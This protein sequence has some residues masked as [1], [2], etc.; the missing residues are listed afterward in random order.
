MQFSWL[1]V[2]LLAFVVVFG[3][4]VGIRQNGGAVQRRATVLSFVVLAVM[5]AISC[6]A[7]PLLGL[8]SFIP[9]FSLVSFILPLAVYAATVSTANDQAQ[10]TPAR[11]VRTGSM[12]PAHAKIARKEPLM[13]SLKEDR[14]EPAAPSRRTRFIAPLE[15]APSEGAS[16][17]MP[18]A[19]APQ[20]PTTIPTVDK[21]ALQAV[22]E[23]ESKKP[24]QSESATEYG[25]A[26]SYPPPLGEVKPKRSVPTDA[27]DA[28]ELP[29]QKTS[30]PAKME[31]VP[32][33]AAPKNSLVEQPSAVLES[34]VA[35]RQAA[36]LELTPT[37]K[38]V[39][40]PK[41]A[42]TSKPIAAPKPAPAPKPVATPKPAPQPEPVRPTSETCF[43]KAAALKDKG[44]HVV[45][46]R[47]FAESA[48]LAE[49]ESGRRRARFE[50]LACYVKA[51]QPER[52]RALA[53][54]LREQSQVMTKVERIKLDAVTRM[55]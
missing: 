46:A 39:A 37:S 38:P 12:N 32:V 31:T 41:P 51:N 48:A 33:A 2:A 54:E 28:N 42:P 35:P 47:L 11:N 53:T 5:G 19:K 40:T 26:V 6:I 9:L 49:D 8:T 1:A 34:A 27:T 4:V 45:A 25:A 50:E 14:A 13:V 16:I 15:E 43:S 23:E 22:Q 17:R 24:V 7:V 10:T 44:A 20:V 18:A 3:A 29:L 21:E 30:A 52:A 55:L 36:A